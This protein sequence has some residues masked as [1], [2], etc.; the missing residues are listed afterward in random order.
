MS[1]VLELPPLRW[2]CASNTEPRRWVFEDRGIVIG[3]AIR[4]DSGNWL[5]RAYTAETL[6]TG[7]EPSSDLA[8]SAASQEIRKYHPWISRIPI[9]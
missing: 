1:E 8:I 4:L 5:W 6:Y 3:E 2:V 9:R 7:I